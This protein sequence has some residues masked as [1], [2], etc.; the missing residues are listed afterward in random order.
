ML[1][2]LD[3]H[4][5]IVLTKSCKFLAFLIKLN[6]KLNK[7]ALKIW[8]IH[9]SLHCWYFYSYLELLYKIICSVFKLRIYFN[10]FY[11]C[12]VQKICMK[13]H[14]LLIAFNESHLKVNYNVDVHVLHLWQMWQ[15][16][17]RYYIH[18]RSISTR[19]TLVVLLVQI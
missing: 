14:K 12:I 10:S 4:N 15:T 13:E 19:F 18:L 7:C 2:H 1:H 17:I 6:D 3:V 5:L 8:R 11:L 9:V 16:W